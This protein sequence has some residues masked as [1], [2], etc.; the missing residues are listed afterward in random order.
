MLAINKTAAAAVKREDGHYKAIPPF[1]FW[2]LIPSSPS[3]G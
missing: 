2:H 1:D 3:F